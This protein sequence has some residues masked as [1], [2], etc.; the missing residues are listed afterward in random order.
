MADRATKSDLVSSLVQ[1]MK[2]GEISKEELF[3]QLSRVHR[4]NQQVGAKSGSS[5]GNS[6]R[7]SSRNSSSRVGVT[8]NAGQSSQAKSGGVLATASSRAK[9]R[10]SH[11]PAAVPSKTRRSTVGMERSERQALIQVCQLHSCTFPPCALVFNH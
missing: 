9:P 4:Q 2:A 8:G 6:S 7:S 11:V 1:R 10:A 3:V 5:T